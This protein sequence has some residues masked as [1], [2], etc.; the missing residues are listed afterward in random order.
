MAQP[1]RA[2]GRKIFGGIVVLFGALLIVCSILFFAAFGTGERGEA[3]TVWQECLAGVTVIIFGVAAFFGK[4]EFVA[5]I[6][7]FDPAGDPGARPSPG[8]PSLEGMLSHS[9]DVV[10][11]LRDI[12]A[13]GGDGF[14]AV[15]RRRDA[16][17]RRRTAAGSAWNS[18]SCHQSQSPP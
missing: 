16:C 4:P 3:R 18:S 13:H 17:R 10:A 11:T 12:V 6:S 2:L 7:Q 1:R 5:R 8:S 9:E 15:R 14:G